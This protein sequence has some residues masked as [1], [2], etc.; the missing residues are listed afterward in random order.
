MNFVLRK[1]KRPRLRPTNSLK[2]RR[3]VLSVWNPCGT[4]SS[5]ANPTVLR[6]LFRALRR[7]IPTIRFINRG[8]L[9][10]TLF[11]AIETEED[12]DSAID[13]LV[14]EGVIRDDEKEGM[15][16]EVVQKAFSS[17]EIQDWYSGEWT[18]FS[19]CAIIY[20]EKGVLQ[21][22]RPDR[23]MMKENQVVVVDFKFG[24]ENP[25]YNKQV[26]GYM[27]L[28]LRW[29]TRILPVICGMWMRRE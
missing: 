21:T 12:I 10:H 13:R 14:F 29:G 23:V 28:L 20:K 1:K 8:R 17:P 9:L 11:S 15:V 7:K 24:K 16:R 4:T 25:K 26:K 5:S 27:Q 22:R 19:E 18:L 3:N 2:N 6:T